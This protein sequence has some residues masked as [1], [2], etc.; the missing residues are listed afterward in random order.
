MT[1]TSGGAPDTQEPLILEKLSD[2]KDQACFLAH[3]P[4]IRGWLVINPMDDE[5]GVVEDI[6]VNPRNHQVDMAAITFNNAIGYGGKRILVPVKELRIMEGR[7]RVMPHAE[8]IRLAPE[9]GEAVQSYE[10]Y[11]EY[12]TSR[13]APHQEETTVKR[14]Q[15]NG[16]LELEGVEFED[17]EEEEEIEIR[18]ESTSARHGRKD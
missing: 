7:V 17:E 4:D 18:G 12:W 11:Y 5:V 3:Y 15:V 9:F 16:R 8:R 2:L 14:M 1:E 10:P 13:L 6:Y